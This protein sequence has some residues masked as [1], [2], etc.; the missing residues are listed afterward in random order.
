[1]TAGISDEFIMK[2]TTRLRRLGL[3]LAGSV[4]VASLCAPMVAAA[5]AKAP[6]AAK[7]KGEVALPPAKE[8]IAKYVKALGGRDAI[9]K[10]TSTHVKGNFEVPAQGIKGSLEVFAAKPDK[11]KV[12]IDLPGVGVALYGHDGKVGWSI[13]PVLGPMVLDGK[14]L[15]QLKK[16]A[17]YYSALHDEN[18]YKSMETVEIVQFEG[19]EC[20]KL[21]LVRQS[22]EES[23]EYY[24]TKTGLLIGLTAA[25]ESPL[26]SM[27]VTSIASDY[28]K[29]GNL[30]MAT[31]TTQKIAGLQQ[32]MT[33]ETVEYNK[34]TDAEFELPAQIKA[35]VTK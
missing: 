3:R 12:K 23:T 8:V 10:Y 32:V 25:Q 26:G 6:S 14:R 34:V 24:D 2:G 31:K 35:L 28:K 29:F 7:E 15:D 33:V 19:K 21:K 1:M 17:N 16:E 5:Q 30:L 22:G 11:L 4:F 27:T 20:H 9:L 18:D 13:D